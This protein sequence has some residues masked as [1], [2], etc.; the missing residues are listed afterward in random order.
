MIDKDYIS[1][2]I[3]IIVLSIVY[4]V[5]E[6]FLQVYRWCNQEEKMFFNHYIKQ[7]DAISVREDDGIR[8]L[9]KESFIILLLFLHVLLQSG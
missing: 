9:S 7:F 5:D 6:I 8:I 2:V 3:C 1:F 4:I